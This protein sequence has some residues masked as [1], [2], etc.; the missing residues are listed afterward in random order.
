MVALPTSSGTFDADITTLNPAIAICDITN[1]PDNNCGGAGGTSAVILFTTTSTPP[2]TVD[3]TTPQYQGKLG[4]P[5]AGFVS[6]PTHRVHL[7]AG[8]SGAR[9]GPGFPDV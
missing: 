4:N 2:I 8:A 6:S 5:G 9:G 7:T 1:G 3:L